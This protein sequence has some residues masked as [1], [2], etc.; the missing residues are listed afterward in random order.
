MGGPA[1]LVIDIPHD[2]ERAAEK[3][4]DKA[5]E[6]LADLES[7]Y[8]RYQP[9]SLISN[10]NNCAGSGRFTELDTETKALFDLA[11]QLWKESEGLFD[12]TSRPLAACLVLSGG[13]TCCP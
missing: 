11:G 2:A 12:I 6:L 3:T 8:S 13:C 5:I 4:L 9:T 10:I 1:L 7:R